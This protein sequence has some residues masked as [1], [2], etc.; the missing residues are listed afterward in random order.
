MVD[1]GFTTTPLPS[2]PLKREGE[3]TFL[4]FFRD[5]YRSL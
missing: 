4:L 3:R 2:P 5:F 1:V